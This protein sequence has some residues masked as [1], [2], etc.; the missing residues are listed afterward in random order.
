MQKEAEPDL[1]NPGRQSST[2]SGGGGRTG[3]WVEL[4][5]KPNRLLALGSIGVEKLASF[6][7]LMV[8][9]WETQVPFLAEERF[10]DVSVLY[11]AALHAGVSSNR[12]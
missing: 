1:L 11:C 4:A 10:A 2:C 6:G 9:Q 5:G 8:Q 12:K 3:S 7:G